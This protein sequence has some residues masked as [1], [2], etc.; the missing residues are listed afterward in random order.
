MNNQGVIQLQEGALEYQGG[1]IYAGTQNIIPVP[2]P[3][4]FGFL[5]L[6]VLVFGLRLKPV[7]RA[8]EA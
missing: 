3:G 4:A 2:E 1:G 6:G 5:G 8:R 7:R